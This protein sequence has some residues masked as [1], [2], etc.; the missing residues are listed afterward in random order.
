V[1]KAL[2]D[3]AIRPS[4]AEAVTADPDEGSHSRQE[5]EVGAIET[6]MAVTRAH[7]RAEVFQAVTPEQ[8]AKAQDFQK[9]MEARRP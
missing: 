1:L 5:R 9:R 8:R 7:V 6:D 3:R 2:N 4:G